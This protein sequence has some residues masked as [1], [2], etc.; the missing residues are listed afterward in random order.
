MLGPDDASAPHDILRRDFEGKVVL[1]TGASSGIGAAVAKAFGAHGA[2]VVVHYGHNRS[3]AEAVAAA[4]GCDALVL[5]ADLA[6]DS[7]AGELVDAIDRRLG[8]IDVLI[9]N[10]GDPLGRWAFLEA[11]DATICRILDLNLNAVIRLCRRAVPSIRR[12]SG[13]AIVN[14][15]S[16]AARTGGGPGM[17]FY[18][19]AKAGVAALTRGLA[20]EL[21]TE[22]IRVNAV[23]PGVIETP[24]H[25]RLSSADHLRKAAASVPLGRMGTP[26]E[27]IGAYLCL[28][29]PTLGG[30]LT[31]QTIEVNGGLLM[32]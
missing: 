7:A 24:L 20:R 30:Y 28:A 8:G 17:V 15:T 32:P 26:E 31:G 11:D 29:S 13:G 27:C 4:I 23:S 10:A 14:T 16:I 18:A 25:A 19:I 3:G 22:G 1:V 2:R 21:A 12:R 9:N 5:G 6:I